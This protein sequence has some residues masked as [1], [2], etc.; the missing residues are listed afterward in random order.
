MKWSLGLKQRRKLM[1]AKRFILVGVEM[2]KK[3][4]E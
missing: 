4:F 1:D 3:K 2:K